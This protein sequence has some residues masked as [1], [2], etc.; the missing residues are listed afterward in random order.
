MS[1]ETVINNS[2]FSAYPDKIRVLD[3]Y[4]HMTS[5][6]YW[7]LWRSVDNMVH[8]DFGTVEINCYYT[9]IVKLRNRMN[10]YASVDRGYLLKQIWPY[11]NIGT[12]SDNLLSF[13]KYH[14]NIRINPPEIH[15][16]I[17]VRMRG[18]GYN[19][20]D[21]VFN[22]LRWIFVK[23]TPIEDGVIDKFDLV[24]FKY[25]NNGHNY[26][27]INTIIEVLKKSFE[28]MA[29]SIAYAFALQIWPKKL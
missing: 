20:G 6:D 14:A 2:G 11:V 19:N 27:S 22:D 5:K 29:E 10:Q 1:G 18:D 25:P 8:H 26:T 21:I 13:D 7:I 24:T 15:Y 28:D 23:Y 9:G 17:C 3:E 4:I 12:V 16:T